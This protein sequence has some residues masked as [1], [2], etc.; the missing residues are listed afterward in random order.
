M[1]R[2]ISI[3]GGKG[4][5]GKTNV[6]L[7]LSL[8]LSKLGSR[9]CLFDADLGLANINILLGLYP[10]YNLEDLILKKKEIQD[11]I[12]K[13]YEGVDIIPGSSGVE[14]IAN[15]AQVDI[16]R[17]IHSFSTLDEYDF[18]IFDTSSGISRNVISFCL[19]A[20]EVVLVITPEPTSLTDA[21][22]LLKVLCLN[23]FSGSAQVVINHCKDTKIASNTYNRFKDVVQQYLAVKLI[24]LGI[25][26]E[27]PKFSKAVSK[28]KPLVTLYPESRAS[29]CINVMA[30]RLKTNKYEDFKP[31]GIASF[32]SNFLEFT[33][34]PLKLTAKAE[35]ENEENTVA[36]H[37]PAIK[38]SIPLEIEK[39]KEVTSADKPGDLAPQ[40]TLQDE[41]TT[42]PP[43]DASRVE[44]GIESS[45]K[46]YPYTVKNRDSHPL[47]DRL[48][49]SNNL[50]TL[51]HILLKMIK[52]CSDED[53]SITELGEIAEKDPS[54]CTKILRMVNSAHYNLTQ[55]VK[56]IDQALSLLGIDAVRNI[57]VSASVSQVFNNMGENSSFNMKLFWWHSLM[58]AVLADLIAKKTSYPHPDEAF[59]SGL[60]HDIGKLVLL[61]NYPDEYQEII[62]ASENGSQ[63]FIE[64]DERLGITH[65]E[66]GARLIKHWQ[67]QSFVGDAI[68][69]HHEPLQRIVNALP[70]VKIIYAANYLCSVGYGNKGFNPE[71]VK[72]IID[73]QV[74]DLAELSEQAE[75]QV[76]EIAQ[77]LD[78]DIESPSR[79]AGISVS[80]RDTEIQADL[81][82]EVRDMS[83]LLGTL[84]N[85][86]NAHDINSILQVTRQGLQILFDITNSLFFL[87][88]SSQNVLTAE[89][90]NN[91]LINDL[92]DELTIPFQDSKSILVG[93]LR[94]GTIVSS[95]NYGSQFDLTIIDEQ[96]IRLTD[97]DGIY[98]FPMVA[99][100]QYVGVMVLG[101]EES[102]I[103]QLNSRQKMLS[104]FISYAAF[105]LHAENGRQSQAKLV[106]SERLAASE[107]IAKRVA[108]EVNNPLS[109]IKNY[110]KILELNLSD[111]NIQ[112]DE[113]KIIQEEIKRVSLIIEELS[114]FSKPKA[115]NP[116][117]LNINSLLSDIAKLTGEPLSQKGIEIHLEP[118]PDLPVIVTDKNSLQQVFVNLIKNASEAL[119]DNGNIY[120]TTK[121]A[122]DAGTVEINVSDDGPGLPDV[123][124]SRLFEPYT[125]TKG[126]GHTGLGL[127]IVYSTVRGIKGKVTC[128]TNKGQGTTFKIILPM[129]IASENDAQ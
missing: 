63:L 58:C 22:A 85:L 79:E 81:T 1:T 89:K 47:F 45:Q 37:E 93:A 30:F 117:P 128:S 40:E 86:L 13:D 70:L 99:R 66:T 21:Y 97:K 12:I 127:S 35:N 106:L 54:L 92:T 36:E 8:C 32:W 60:L 122:A 118:D 95:F 19:A 50:P 98:C 115:L 129:S 14:K 76:N 113:L 78:I 53:I 91:S 25:I 94:K 9:V 42:R 6:S 69:Y 16:D 4:G 26:V 65:F 64:E 126:K 3:T 29:K 52:S 46:D 73:L 102:H 124:K 57:A 17:I 15:L 61:A 7:N 71:T 72:E 67:L 11:I 55:K 87:Y 104:R 84:Q 31:M 56:K 18:F 28:Q 88:D 38:E 75:V 107:A 49:F 90:G 5:V 82:F 10:E 116:E 112:V 62:N 2:I 121:H 109:I 123:I 59:L 110:I 43:Y 96:L 34:R 23:G 101:I 120:I 48:E 77:S 114:D 111:H 51:P 125:S 108:H 74:S 20:S 103:A 39:D 83:L 119:T 33:K 105:A 24:P 68:L 44:S 41:K 80:E 27:D 100:K